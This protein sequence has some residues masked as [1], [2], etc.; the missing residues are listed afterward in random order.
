[1]HLGT[2]ISTRKLSRTLL[3][4]ADKRSAEAP[5]GVLSYCYAQY[6]CAPASSSLWYLSSSI[7]M[8]AAAAE[9]D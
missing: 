6:V 2:N 7:D 1:M 8:N 9:E 3:P 5:R 4:R